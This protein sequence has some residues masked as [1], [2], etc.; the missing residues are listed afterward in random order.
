M[1]N[2]QWPEVAQNPERKSTFTRRRFASGSMTTA[3]RADH[4]GRSV[5]VI[6]SLKLAVNV[7]D[8]AVTIAWFMYERNGLRKAMAV[9]MVIAVVMLLLV[10]LPVLVLQKRLQANELDLI[11]RV[12]GSDNPDI[13]STALAVYPV[14]WFAHRSVVRG[15]DPADGEL[16]A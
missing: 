10:P 5:P 11:V 1:K 3:V 6:R 15:T 14:Q 8:P 12:E 16:E 13:V 9:T 2:V 4:A 7:D